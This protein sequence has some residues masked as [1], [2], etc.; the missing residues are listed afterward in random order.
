MPP[1]I[2]D[3]FREEER[4]D[5]NFKIVAMLQPHNRQAMMF[6]HCSN[7]RPIGIAA[8]KGAYATCAGS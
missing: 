6:L 5:H 8:R 2:P 1:I 3:R 4:T 7:A